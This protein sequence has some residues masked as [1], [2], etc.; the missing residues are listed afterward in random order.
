M[1]VRRPIADSDSGLSLYYIEVITTTCP[2]KTS[3]FVNKTF[4][5]YEEWKNM[6]VVTLFTGSASFIMH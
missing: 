1:S 3:R 6:M 5:N 4:L 2:N